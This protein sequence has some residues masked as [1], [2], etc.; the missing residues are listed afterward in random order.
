MR[1]DEKHF[2]KL[3]RR[4]AAGGILLVLVVIAIAAVNFRSDYREARLQQQWGLWRDDHCLLTDAPTPHVAA[5]PQNATIYDAS[6]LQGIPG[7]WQC[8]DGRTYTLDDSS[9]PPSGWIPPP[10]DAS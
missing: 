8:V 2:R 4:L 10:D 5:S 3:R 6:R 9:Q 7:T 1:D